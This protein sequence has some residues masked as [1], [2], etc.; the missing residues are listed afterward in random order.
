MTN[1]EK[2]LL[3]IQELNALVS[4]FMDTN[5]ELQRDNEVGED[6][7]IITR[8]DGQQVR[9]HYTPALGTYSMERVGEGYVTQTNHIDVLLGAV[10]GWAK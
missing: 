9:I 7:V 5:G 6:R 2:N 10:Q 1:K 4:V 8:N 3:K